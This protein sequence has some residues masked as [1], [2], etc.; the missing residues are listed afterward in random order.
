MR[1]PS[2]EAD[3]MRSLTQDQI[4]KSAAY[5]LNQMIMRKLQKALQVDPE[6]DILSQIPSSYSSRLAERKMNGSSLHI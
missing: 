4:S 1:T 2:N 3:T 5:Q 6:V